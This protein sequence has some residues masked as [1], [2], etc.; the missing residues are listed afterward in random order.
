MSNQNFIYDKDGNLVNV[1]PSGSS[2]DVVASRFLMNTNRPS[3]LFKDSVPPTLR[4][5]T[6]KVVTEQ[7]QINTVFPVLSAN[8]V[9]GYPRNPSPEDLDVH[10]I[11]S[12]YPI[13][14]VTQKPAEKIHP[15]TTK[16][17]TAEKIPNPNKTV[18]YR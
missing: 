8:S 1:L 13:L 5:S 18:R 16:P 6:F 12:A 7:P 10:K 17:M 14:G 3:S 15:S 9:F 11:T 4:A 2:G